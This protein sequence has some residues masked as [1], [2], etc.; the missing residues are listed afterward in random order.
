MAIAEIR[1]SELGEPEGCAA[2]SAGLDSSATL[3]ATYTA[4]SATSAEPPG[5]P[6]PSGPYLEW[7]PFDRFSNFFA[8]HIIAEYLEG[9]GVPTVVENSGVS[10]D[11]MNPCTLW[12]PKLLA[13]RARW[14]LTW[15]LSSEAERM[16]LATENHAEADG[17]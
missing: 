15:P 7:G 11:G 5:P 14:F 1:P 4:H 2:T 17:L 8:A 10:P 6:L 13:H 3:S 9:V 12:V 16:F